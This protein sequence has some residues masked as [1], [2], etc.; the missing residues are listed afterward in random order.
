MTDRLVRTATIEDAAAI[1]AIYAPYV[2]LT[3]ITFEEV[4]PSPEEM[5]AR[6]AETGRT[7]PWLVLEDEAGELAGYAY[8]CP[9][10]SRA[11]YRWSVDAAV[12]V[13]RQSTARGVGRTLYAAL[14]PILARQGFHAAYAG[15]TLPNAA[16]VGLHESF[17]FEPVGVYREV[18]FKHGLWHDVGWWRKPLNPGPPA[19]EPGAP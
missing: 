10:R 17:G 16:S 12:Y 1:A 9:H 13:R 6:M 2:E 18:G 4:A 7:H 11:A 5:A 15:I 14:F 3:A 8:A 19:G